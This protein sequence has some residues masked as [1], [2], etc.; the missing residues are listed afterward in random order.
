MTQSRVLGILVWLK[1]RY[2]IGN[3]RQSKLPYITV[4][5]I[6]NDWHLR[7]MVSLPQSQILVSDA[8]V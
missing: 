7:V 6:Q 5:S 4:L 1:L 3:R 2:E 8:L